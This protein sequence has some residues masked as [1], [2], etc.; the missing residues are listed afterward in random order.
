MAQPTRMQFFPSTHIAGVALTVIALMLLLFW[1]APKTPNRV[2]EIVALPTPAEQP[3]VKQEPE[4]RWEEDQ[5]KS[6]GSLSALFSRNNLSAADVIDIAAVAPREVTT[7]RPGQKVRWIRSGENRISEMEVILSPLA[8]HHIERDAEGKLTYHLLERNADY[9]PRFAETRIENSLF[10]DGERAGIPEAVLIDVANLFGW[11][12]DFAL[13]IRKG[14]EMSVIYQEIFLDGE[15]I[16]NGPILAARF[17]NHGT[18][19]TAIRYQ[20]SKGNVSYYNAAGQSMRKAFLRNP[21]DFFRISSRFNLNRKHP[22]LNTIRAHRGTD[23]AA[24]VG[25]PVKAAG[26]GKVV[27]AGRQNGFGN[28]IKIQHGQRYQTLYAHLNGFARD[29][30][31]GRTV[32]QGQVIGYVGKTGLATGPHL[33]YEFRVDGVHRDSLSIKFPDSEPIPANERPAFNK[34]SAE[35]TSWLNRLATSTGD[36]N[37]GR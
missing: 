26:D 11:D 32:R 34:V 14:D 29:V 18:L 36:A 16:G 9:L 31:S 20:D 19:Y 37:S 30:R 6:G 7:L 24:P 25:T 10:L 1:P 5:I 4:V 23:Y 33:H 8:R 21:I 35:M 28:V 12:I 2:Q 22:I 3:Q 15:K 13:D 17:M 27:F